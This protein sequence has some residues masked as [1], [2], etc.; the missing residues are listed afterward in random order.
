MASEEDLLVHKLLH[1]LIVI[2]GYA[3]FLGDEPE[4]NLSQKQKKK[5]L[6]IGKTAF[7][8]SNIIRKHINREEK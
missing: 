1:P 8:L 5:I 7:A 4:S 3:L 2:H 6:D